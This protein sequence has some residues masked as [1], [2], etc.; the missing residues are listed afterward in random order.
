MLSSPH[1]VFLMLLRELFELGLLVRCANAG[2]IHSTTD[3]IV[4]S[5]IRHI[6]SNI[7]ALLVRLDIECDHPLQGI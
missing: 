3:V 6:L 4:V 2:G 5:S 7:P 1:V